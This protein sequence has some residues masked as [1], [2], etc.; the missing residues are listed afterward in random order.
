MWVSNYD[1]P[2]EYDGP[3]FTKETQERRIQNALELEARLAPLG[4]QDWILRCDPALSSGYYLQAEHDKMEFL[5]LIASSKGQYSPRTG[6]YF[7]E[8]DAV[9]LTTDFVG[10]NC[11]GDVLRVEHRFDGPTAIEEAAAFIAKLPSRDKTPDRDCYYEVK[12]P[13]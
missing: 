2:E 8:H 5:V 13:A 9:R 12:L 10:E 7:A 4:K 6:N 11:H 3:C 1:R